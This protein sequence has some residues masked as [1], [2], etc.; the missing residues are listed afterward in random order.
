MDDRAPAT[1]L[2]LG[3]FYVVGVIFGVSAAVILLYDLS[4]CITGQASEADMVA[5][6]ESEEH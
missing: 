1:G 3:I 6:K 2:S 4:G 5:V